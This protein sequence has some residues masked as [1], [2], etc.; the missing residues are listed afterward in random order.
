[1]S[2]QMELNVVAEG[3]ETSEQLTWLRQIGCNEVQGYYFSRPMPE[4]DTLRYM[5]VFQKTDQEKVLGSP[6]PA[7]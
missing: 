4:Q 3:V 6:A 1:M 5:K 7:F 2:K